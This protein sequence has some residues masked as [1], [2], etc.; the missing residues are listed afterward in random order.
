MK[1][2]VS[3]LKKNVLSQLTFRFSK[4]RNKQRLMLRLDH[5]YISTL[6][7]TIFIQYFIQFFEKDWYIIRLLN[8]QSDINP[9][10]TNIPIKLNLVNLTVV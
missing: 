4:I 5:W 3:F 8:Y 1:R 6:F 9:F 2:R 7:H 10:K